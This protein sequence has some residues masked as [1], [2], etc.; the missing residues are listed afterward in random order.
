M[1]SEEKKTLIFNR[2]WVA[3]KFDGPNDVK[4]IH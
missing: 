3:Y 4:A 2:L 1:A